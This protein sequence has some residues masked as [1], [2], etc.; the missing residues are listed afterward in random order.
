M[1]S[2]VA[3]KPERLQIRIINGRRTVR[4]SECSTHLYIPSNAK[5]K[6]RCPECSEILYDPEFGTDSSGANRCNNPSIE[7]TNARNNG[8]IEKEPEDLLPP[9]PLH[10]K[11]A[12]QGQHFDSEPEDP[13]LI[14]EPREPS[15]SKD[16]EDYE[17]LV[18]VLPGHAN[19]KVIQS[20]FPIGGV[21]CEL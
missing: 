7:E 11:L 15:E 9:S 18:K 19:S 6:F 3:S 8:S 2:Q 16:T 21:D 12:T 17:G 10:T 14:I 1:T 20:Y 5:P 13:W 4:C